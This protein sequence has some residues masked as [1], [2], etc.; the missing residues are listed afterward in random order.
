M[1]LSKCLA[2]LDASLRQFG[3]RLLQR[4]GNA[5][6]VLDRLAADIDITSLLVSNRGCQAPIKMI[7]QSYLPYEQ[8]SA[9]FSRRVNCENTSCGRVTIHI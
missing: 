1:L 9:T 6:E 8:R 3:V 4:C 7:T 5:T 2:D